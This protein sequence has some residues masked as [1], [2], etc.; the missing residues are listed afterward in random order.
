M[1]SQPRA[2]YKA[3]LNTLRD[4][5]AHFDAFYD[6][7]ACP[8]WHFDADHDSH[9]AY[10][11]NTR[12]DWIVI[13]ANTVCYLDAHSHIFAHPDRQADDDPVSR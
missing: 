3:D 10:Y 7:H 9:D 12:A 11:T 8:D 4:I 6:A 13:D 1:D 2:D 5:T